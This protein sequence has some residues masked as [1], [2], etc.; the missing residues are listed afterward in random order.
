MA[1]RKPSLWSRVQIPVVALAITV[2]LGGI[3]LG[4]GIVHF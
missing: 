4:T 2:V 1:A 3:L